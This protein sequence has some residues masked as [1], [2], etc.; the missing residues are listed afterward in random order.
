M[1]TVYGH[2]CAWRVE[3]ELFSRTTSIQASRRVFVKANFLNSYCVREGI[4]GRRKLMGS[5]QTGKEKPSEQI[6]P[7]LP[8]GGEEEDTWAGGAWRLVTEQ[9]CLENPWL[10]SRMNCF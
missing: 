1:N 10:H 4:E 3:N 5:H 9:S 8:G 2:E 7:C 6:Y